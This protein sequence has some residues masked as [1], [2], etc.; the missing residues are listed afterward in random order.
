MIAMGFG[1]AA[2]PDPALRADPK[3]ERQM[4][5]PPAAHADAVLDDRTRAALVANQETAPAA[6]E[7][8]GADGLTEAERRE[9]ERLRARDREVREH[10]MAHMTAGGSY[11]SQPSFR[12]VRGPDGGFYAVG[13][14]VRIDTSPVPGNPEATIRKMQTIKRAAL[15]PREPSSQDRRVAAEAEAAIIRARRE[16]SEQERQEQA[17]RAERRDEQDATRRD[18]DRTGLPGNEPAFDPASRFRAANGGTGRLPGP[19]LV[20]AGDV[21]TEMT[22]TLDAGALFDLVA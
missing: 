14:E 18:K 10:E 20:G 13:G 8:K 16:L 7:K 2:L 17:A 4:R 11:A 22:G 3:G 21:D 1:H 12:F 6:E 9:V 5:P 15:A 19:D